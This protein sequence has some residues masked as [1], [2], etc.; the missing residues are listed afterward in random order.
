M[1][2]ALLFKG[3]EMLSRPTVT[4]RSLAKKQIQINVCIVYLAECWPFL[5]AVTGPECK[6]ASLGSHRNTE[7]I[8]RGSKRE[9]PGA[10]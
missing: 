2:A 1:A 9:G 3:R 4:C 10:R 6:E 5:N 8:G 7:S